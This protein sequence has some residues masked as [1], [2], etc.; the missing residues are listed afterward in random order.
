LEDLPLFFLI[1]TPNE[2]V[3]SCKCKKSRKNTTV[4]VEVYSA[5]LVL[6]LLL[7]TSNHCERVREGKKIS[8]EERGRFDIVSIQLS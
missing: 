4:Y 8:V 2:I 6:S 1:S 5:E 7:A 3:N